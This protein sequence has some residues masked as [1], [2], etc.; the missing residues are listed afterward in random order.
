MT[1][2]RGA[3]SKH[4]AP[5]FRK[6]LFNS[7]K[8]R[9]IEGRALVN[10]N[11]SERAYEEDF[12]VAGF[13]ALQLKPEGASVSYQDIIE[14]TKKRFTW[15]TFGLAWRIT[16]EMAEDDLYGTF[17]NKM[18]KAAGRSARNNLEVIMHA[19]Y[20][21][22]FDNTV[23]GFKSGEALCDTH[24]SLRGVSQTNKVV[25]DLDLLSLQAA[26]EHFATL[27]DESGFPIMINPKLLVHSIGDKWIVAQLLK[28]ERLPGTNANDINQMAREGL[29]AHLSHG[30]ITDTDA[31]FLLGD[32]HFVQYF[33]RR[34]M[35]MRNSD[36]SETGDAR[37]N[38]T[39]RHGSGFSYW[40]GVFGGPGV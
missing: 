34:A 18:S 14:G 40:Y 25:S 2:F 15:S 26:V 29:S 22:A 24:T 16:E 10:F 17:G 19:P 11:T 28:S 5:G 7:F 1:M 27:V 35:R 37:F 23:I 6:V 3:F 31:W 36:D 32:E 12:P 38:V 20:N 4:L 33:Q 30:F 39:Q 13:G 8:E 21:S 9:P